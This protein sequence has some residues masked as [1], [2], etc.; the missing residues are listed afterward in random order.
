MNRI[1]PVDELHVEHYSQGIMEFTATNGAYENPFEGTKEFILK[2][3]KM[4][5]Y[6]DLKTDLIKYLLKGNF[7]LAKKVQDR[8]EFISIDKFPSEMVLLFEMLMAMLIPLE[9]KKFVVGVLRNL[10]DNGKFPED[11][12]KE[13]SKIYENKWKGICPG[14]E[15]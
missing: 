9:T 3:R 12:G 6:L 8:L 4:E 11:V 2:V 1:K 14:I 13:L 7:I 10:N 15:I 5:D